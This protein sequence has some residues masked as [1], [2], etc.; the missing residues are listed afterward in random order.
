MHIRNK[1]II[2]LLSLLGLLFHL[3][4]CAPT[5]VRRALENQKPTVT[6]TDKKLSALDFERAELLFG[7]E[8]SNPNPV[9]LSLAGLDYEL[10]L[11]GRSFVSGSQQETMRLVASGKS[12]I[13]LPLS[14]AFADIYQGLKEMHGKHEVPYE[15]S[16]VLHIDVPLLGKLRFPVTTKGV[17]PLPRLPRVSLKGI[18]LERLSL[19]SATLS[20]KLQVENP[21]AFGLGLDRLRYELT[22][23]GRPWVSADKRALGDIKAQQGNTLS[24]PL[25]LNFAEIGGGL[26]ALLSANRSLDYRLSGSLDARSDNPLI[27]QF[28]M[29]F[30]SSGSTN[31]LR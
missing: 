4:A 30:S 18:Q 3:A 12:R 26:Y 28:D 20:L 5:D 14:L 31:L 24:L 10:K 25:T 17:L 27:G 15:L 19:S 29:P 8:V 2:S 13:D 7:F 9:A 23:N 1:R 6:L 21:N 16:T 11:A 22:V